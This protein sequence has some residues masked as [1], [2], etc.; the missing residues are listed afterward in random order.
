[1]DT[2]TADFVICGTNDDIPNDCPNPFVIE[3]QIRGFDE[4]TANDLH[5]RLVG[6]DLNHQYDVPVYE[7]F[8]NQV[9]RD[10]GGL[11]DHSPYSMEVIVLLYRQI[12][13]EV[14]CNDQVVAIGVGGRYLD[15][16]HDLADNEGLEL[17]VR[18]QPEESKSDRSVRWDAFQWVPIVLFDVLCSLFLKLVFRARTAST[19]VLYPV[20]RPETFRPLEDNLDVEYNGSVYVLTLSYLLNYRSIFTDDISVVPIHCFATV[21]GFLSQCRFALTFARDIHSRKTERTL[22]DSVED[23][24]GLRLEQTVGS[25]Y[26]RAAAF[27]FASC[28]RYE[29]AKRAFKQSQYDVLMLPSSDGLNKAIGLAAREEDVEVLLLP[30][31]ILHQYTALEVPYSHTRVVEGSIAREPLRDVEGVEFVE[32]GL[33]KHLTIRDRAESIERQS[34]RKQ[35]LIGTQPYEDSR[36][37]EF[38]NDVVNAS[39]EETNHDIVVKI[40]PRE[41]VEF[42]ESVMEDLD[43]NEANRQRISITE[44]N[45]HRNI[46]D[47][48]LMVTISSNVGIESVILGTPTICYNK[49]SPDIRTPLYATDGRVPNIEKYED[50]LQAYDER[51]FS[52]LYRSQKRM[53]DEKFMVRGNTIQAISEGIRGQI[54]KSSALSTDK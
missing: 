22:V 25:L 36:R 24:T 51:Q 14:T 49:W 12:V 27:N 6:L 44:R 7:V 15:M 19:L 34:E 47:S 3:R 26:Q 42:Y 21:R 18:D 13:E 11:H 31:S 40:H 39:L 46:A 4:E 5:N 53:L 10:G 33:P 52:D 20:F 35:I 54:R 30:H 48:D 28:L 29:T 37:R 41:K 16:L 50:L 45:L 38:I 1:M 32:L 43:L 17:V 8:G 9:W 2:S 23:E